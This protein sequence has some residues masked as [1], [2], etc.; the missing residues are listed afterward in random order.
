MICCRCWCH[1]CHVLRWICHYRFDVVLH[2]KL[3]L[4]VLWKIK[5][6]IKILM[7]FPLVLVNCD[8][9]PNSSSERHIILST[10]FLITWEIFRSSACHRMVCWDPRITLLARHEY[11]GLVGNLHLYSV[12]DFLKK[13]PYRACRKFRNKVGSSFIVHMY[14]WNESGDISVRSYD[15]FPYSHRYITSS[16]MSA[17]M[18]TPWMSLV[19]HMVGWNS[20]H[21]TAVTP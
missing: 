14:W 16:S 12:S 18:N 7:H 3:H 19:V 2:V 21:A 6:H 5:S 17:W 10:T 9:F 4:L 15:I 1:T 20:V 13:V 8:S 11:Y